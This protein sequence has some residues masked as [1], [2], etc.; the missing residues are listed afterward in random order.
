MNEA[1]QKTNQ[2]S[3][4]ANPPEQSSQRS[5]RPTNPL[6]ALNYEQGAKALSP[7][8]SAQGGVQGSGAAMPF[9]DAIQSSFGKHDIQG[10]RAYQGGEADQACDSLGALA[11]VT[12]GK[13]AFK[14]SPTL[15]TA[16]HEAAHF[17]QQASGVAT[18]DGLGR[19]GDSYEQ[20]ADAVADRVVAGLSAESLLD[21]MAGSGGGG[22]GV[23]QCKQ[24]SG[25]AQTTPAPKIPDPA[26]KPGPAT[27]PSK[28]G[29]MSE[30]D[31]RAYL[32]AHDFS[33]KLI[34]KV[35]QA[36]GEF[37]SAVG[38]AIGA[39]QLN[40]A[41]P[42][43]PAE[44]SV[45]TLIQEIV[46]GFIGIAG[47]LLSGF[48]ALALVKP[49]RVLRGVKEGSKAAGSIQKRIDAISKPL[50]AI[51]GGMGA[52]TKATGA[53]K[54]AASLASS[55]G[56]VAALDKKTKPPKKDDLSLLKTS[57]KQR[58]LAAKQTRKALSAATQPLAGKAAKT[59]YAAAAGMEDRFKFEITAI[60]E[61]LSPAMDQQTASIRD[62]FAPQASAMAMDPSRWPDSLKTA[63]H[64]ADAVAESQ[65]NVVVDAA[66]DAMVRRYVVSAL[67]GR[68][69]FVGPKGMIVAANVEKYFSVRLQTIWEGAKAK[70]LVDCA[71]R[72]HRKELG[73]VNDDGQLTGREEATARLRYGHAGVIGYEETVEDITNGD[74]EFDQDFTREMSPRFN[75]GDA[76]EN[77][78]TNY[79][80][81]KLPGRTRAQKAVAGVD[82]LQDRADQRI[83]AVTERDLIVQD[84]SELD[85]V[86][87]SIRK[88]R[89]AELEAK[90]LR[91]KG[92]A[93]P[94]GDYFKTKPSE[95]KMQ[96]EF[97]RDGTLPAS[98]VV[99]G[100]RDT[101]DAEQA[102]YDEFKDLQ[103]KTYED[104]LSEVLETKAGKGK[105][106]PG[107]LRAHIRRLQAA[108][109]L[110]AV[111]FA[112]LNGLLT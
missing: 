38:D 95:L 80:E 73:D 111:H 17:V 64:P 56:P 37:R 99:S 28:T 72:A 43:P 70:Y 18:K 22:G 89:K 94:S 39:I 7:R 8:D 69:D 50:D 81:S 109:K 77:L 27:V 90:L 16:A 4:E 52:V 47:P 31:M 85:Q 10:L 25:Q 42:L 75:L 24:P 20:H 57:R 45:L 34:G 6:R 15:H 32:A 79:D 40:E 76:G 3:R 9:A 58:R 66:A 100:P 106:T 96:R 92:T 82:R 23:V 101:P 36:A 87:P 67:T 65:L 48:K 49:N 108:G 41:L 51:N 84:L 112:I 26:K 83:D 78:W 63:Q 54:K 13:A 110:T 60:Q 62:G 105:R 68:E 61:V 21:E 2:T 103:G 53:G 29:P 102:E 35:H 14:G 30:A 74:A 104:T 11:Y 98:H 59:Q 46:E 44:K 97:Q 88:R 86:H 71:A 33:G 19:S 107:K 55:N 1:A 93:I 5:R 12:D 91:L